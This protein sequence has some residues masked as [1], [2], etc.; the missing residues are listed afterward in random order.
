MKNRNI[1][2]SAIII[3]LLLIFRTVSSQAFKTVETANDVIDN[4]LMAIGAMNL[5]SIY[6][7][8]VDGT[9]NLQGL[10]IPFKEYINFKNKE[11]Y[12]NINSDTI[13]V[14][15]FVINDTIRWLQTN[16][17]GKNFNLDISDI[18]HKVLNKYFI[19]YNYFFFFLNYKKYELNMT[20]DSVKSDNELS[21]RI[22]FS[23]ND[24]LKCTALFDSK[25]FYLEEYKVEAP[26]EDFMGYN[27]FNFVFND[28]K[29]IK[30][31]N[32]HMP[33]SFIMNDFFNITVSSY[34]FNKN[35]DKD[36]LSM[37]EKI[38]QSKYQGRDEQKT[39]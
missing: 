20:F 10:I 9:A 17:K 12:L 37:P 3:F 34:E 24:T 22:A 27:S 18:D 30:E 25:N 29:Q 28:Y 7:Y 19:A 33:F 11:Y 2:L 6:S 16:K 15:K 8:S 1:I 14:L 38:D 13:K 32:I 21:Y 36:L 4:Y 26:T 23:K 5:E 35:I 39:K 31:L